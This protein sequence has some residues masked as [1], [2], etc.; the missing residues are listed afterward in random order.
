TPVH[1]AAFAAGMNR[2]APAVDAPYRMPLNA[3]TLSITNPRTLPAV[4]STMVPGFVSAPHE[5]VVPRIKA[6]ALVPRNFRRSIFFCVISLLLWLGIL[7][8]F[9]QPQRRVCKKS[10]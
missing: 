4:V 7:S 2:F 10:G 9:D 1:V 3:L 6:A 5:R 8:T